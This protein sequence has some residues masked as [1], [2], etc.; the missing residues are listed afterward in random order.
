VSQVGP[1]LVEVEPDPT[2]ARLAVCEPKTNGKLD[3]THI[4]D[5]ISGKSDYTPI[6]SL[7]PVAVYV[8]DVEGRITYFNDAAAALWGCRPRYGDRWCGSWRLYRVDGAPLPH[9]QSPVAVA[10]KE[11]R[12][13]RGEAV[14]ERPDGTRVPFVAFPTPLHD[15]AGEMVG[16]VN[17]LIDV[18]EHHRAER[19]SRHLAA[20]VESSD[21]AIIS[22]DLDGIIATFNRGAENLFGYFA[23]EVIGK[24]I[25][26]LIPAERQDEEIEILARIR[27]GERIDHFETVRQR[28]DGSQVNISLTISP[29]ADETGKI[30]GA[31]KIARNITNQKRREE[32]IALLA[33]EAD[34]RSKN[35][36]AL[37]QAT[38]HLTQADTVD[39]LKEVIEGRLQAL[40]KAHALLAQS[41][42]AG[43]DLRTM[44]VEELSPYMENGRARAEI[45]GPTL[46]LSPDSA[47]AIA[48]AVHELTTNAVKY[49]ALSVPGGRVRIE[50]RLR[51]GNLLTIRWTEQGGPPVSPPNRQGFGTRV[52]E[53]MVCGQC[54]GELDF[55]WRVA[56]V[57]CEIT[58]VT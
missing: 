31:S 43:A 36:L 51:P 38:V 33:R 29:I 28:K 56:G 27:R 9:D 15:A 3:H 4:L 39:E 6:L 57:V 25:T 7:L 48:M 24:P 8:T 34:H 35:L 53:R 20:I 12:A 22:K 32:Q 30:L 1:R 47:Q 40:A 50:W 44:V 37:A 45:T 11:K 21:D 23:E 46:M 19:I 17:I 26:I 42:W 18:S 10:L 52:M 54:N 58:V 14:A 13:V 49:G 55:D 2:V 41:R 5:L 16:T